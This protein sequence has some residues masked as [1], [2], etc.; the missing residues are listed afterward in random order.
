MGAPDELLR[1]LRTI[2]LDNAAS[3]LAEVVFIS[4]TSHLLLLLLLL[5]PSLLPLSLVLLAFPECL[6]ERSKES[7]DERAVRASVVRFE[8]R[9]VDRVVLV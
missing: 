6:P 5:L 1:G 9:V 8:L 4:T 2:G 7:I 3:V